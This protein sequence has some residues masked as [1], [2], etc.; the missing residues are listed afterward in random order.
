MSDD[1][2]IDI[3]QTRFM[4]EIEQLKLPRGNAKPAKGDWTRGKSTSVIELLF[5]T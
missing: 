4:A 1:A 5:L 3:I 2:I